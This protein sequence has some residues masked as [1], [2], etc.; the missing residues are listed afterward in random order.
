M[1]KILEKLKD[2]FD[3]VF[4]DTVLAVGEFLICLFTIVATLYYAITNTLPII[5][6]W[7]WFGMFGFMLIVGTFSLEDMRYLGEDEKDTEE[8]EDEEFVE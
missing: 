3:F 5:P 7:A 6:Q 4:N 8:V 2:G 1:S